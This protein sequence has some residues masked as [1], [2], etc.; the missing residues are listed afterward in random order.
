L[1]HD[2]KEIDDLN[3]MGK[4]YYSAESDQTWGEHERKELF[5]QKKSHFFKQLTIAS[6]SRETLSLKISSFLTMKSKKLSG[7]ASTKS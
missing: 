7:L 4:I 2:L 3:F 1:G 6:L 5:L